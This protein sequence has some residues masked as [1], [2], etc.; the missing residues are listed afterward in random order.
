M[1]TGFKG[2]DSSAVLGLDLKELRIVPYTP[3]QSPYVERLIGSLRRECL[4]HVIVFTQPTSAGGSLIRLETP[5]AL[6]KPL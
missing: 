1:R 6:S 5:L 3:W 2:S 4:E